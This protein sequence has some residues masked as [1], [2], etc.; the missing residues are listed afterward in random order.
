M[1]PL[2]GKLPAATAGIIDA[3]SVKTTESGGPVGYDAGKKVKG[4][5]RHVVVD[6]LGLPL[7]MQV[8]PASIQD[9]DGAPAVIAALRQAMPSVS[10]IW[11]DGGYG[12]AKLATALTG[13]PDAPDLE[14]VPKPE[15][16]Q[17]FVVL[18]RRWV[19]E[20]FF[21]WL[22]RC[23]RLSKD[24]ERTIASALAWLHLA[25]IRILLR[26]LGRA[27]TLGKTTTS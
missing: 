2:E 25:V 10:K 22:G 7:V 1:R 6:T 15:S 14:I 9:R 3:Q 8:H 4:R 18:P 11:A 23:R 24:F 12:G 13:I 5:K 21:G 19:V 26:R 16:Q 27:E 17:G 20:R